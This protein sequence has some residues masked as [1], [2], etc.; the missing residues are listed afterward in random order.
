MMSGCCLGEFRRME[1]LQMIDLTVARFKR[2][3]SNQQRRME[4]HFFRNSWHLLH[5]GTYKNVKY[6]TPNGQHSLHN[7]GVFEYLN[8]I[9]WEGFWIMVYLWSA[10]VMESEALMLHRYNCCFRSVC[11]CM[12]VFVSCLDEQFLCC[13]VLVFVPT[14]VW[15]LTWTVNEKITPLSIISPL[16]FI[17]S[18][19][20]FPSITTQSVLSLP[21]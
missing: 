21:L 9:W 10:I 5:N 4:N 15:L 19:S 3:S 11:V 13:L 8:K 2:S 12:C 17:Y 7:G 16:F 1:R 14:Q 6:E 20:L 18:G